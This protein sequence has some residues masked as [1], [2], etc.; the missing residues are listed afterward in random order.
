MTEYW[1]FFDLRIITPRLT[2]AYPSDAQLEELAALA[3]KGIHEPDYMPFNIP[4][5][6]QPS[7]ELERG[8]LQFH[9][10]GRAQWQPDDWRLEFVASH[11]GRIIGTQGVGARQFAITREAMTGSW[12]GR[13]FQRR[14]LGAEMR[15]AVLHLLFQGLGAVAANSAAREDNVASLKVSQKLGYML[16]GEEVAVIEGRCV[17][18]IRLRIDRQTWESNRAGDI[19]L[20]GLERCL[21]LFGVAPSD[22][23]AE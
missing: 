12:I 22:Q 15:S 2:L 9:W 7:P 1:P 6:R 18:Q 19:R 3:S 13:E 8:L 4:W 5:T 20:E 10:L 16:N 23:L 11:D 17:R 21:G 14:G